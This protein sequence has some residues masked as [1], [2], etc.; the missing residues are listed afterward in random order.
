LSLSSLDSFPV[1]VSKEELHILF[2]V[3]LYKFLFQTVA[4]F[5]FFFHKRDDDHYEILRTSWFSQN[6]LQ[7]FKIPHK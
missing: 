4:M 2:Q 6:M 1:S 7:T 5:T 3:F